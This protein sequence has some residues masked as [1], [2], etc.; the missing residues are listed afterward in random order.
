MEISFEYL[1]FKCRNRKRKCKNSKHIRI[2]LKNWYKNSY[3]IKTFNKSLKVDAIP[4]LS[5]PVG[6]IWWFVKAC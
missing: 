5:N 4:K 1:P 6:I 3:L 2:D